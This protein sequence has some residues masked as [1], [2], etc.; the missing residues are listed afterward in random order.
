[1]HAIA[2]HLPFNSQRPRKSKGKKSSV[3]LQHLASSK[4]F[5]TRFYSFW[6]HESCVR[7]LLWSYT[8][9][10]YYASF[11]CRYV[12]HKVSQ[13]Q[14]TV[15]ASS[16]PV[17]AMPEMQKVWRG[18]KES[19]LW[20]HRRCHPTPCLRIIIHFACKQTHVQS[21]PTFRWM[22]FLCDLIGW[23]EMS[24]LNRNAMQR[25]W[26][27]ANHLCS[28]MYAVC[29]KQNTTVKFNLSFE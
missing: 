22:D 11:G 19:S 27:D 8:V 18:K 23:R 15:E 2:H 26:K 16:V 3:S 12:F 4:R 29:N 9:R 7:V 1:M 6:M 5:S 25:R 14:S 28:I 13:T 10:L 20:K 21:I 17:V 24:Q